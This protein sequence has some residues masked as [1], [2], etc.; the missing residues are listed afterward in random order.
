MAESIVQS[1]KVC[2][3]C[4][5]ACGLDE[6]HVFPGPLRGKSEQYGLKVYLCHDTCHLFGRYAVHRCRETRLALQ[7]CAQAAAMREYGW[8]TADFIREF[9]RNYI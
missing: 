6:H 8:T 4:G 3:L 7:R 1:E 9:G 2:W 5:A